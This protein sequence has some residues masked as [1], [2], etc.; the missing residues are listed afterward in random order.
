MAAKKSTC[1]VRLEAR[2]APDALAVVRRAAQL[3]GRSISNF[4][5]AG[6]LNVAH[7]AV[8]DAHTIW[9]SGCDHWRL[10]PCC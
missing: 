4:L 2:F 3:R 5:L 6:A 7:K 1:T 8:E 9:L 10:L